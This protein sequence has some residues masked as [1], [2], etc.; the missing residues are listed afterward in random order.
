G[1]EA[2]RLGIS[3]EECAES[4][5]HIVSANMGTAIRMVSTDRG[6]DP[7]DQTLVAC[8]GAGGLHACEIAQS[9]SSH[10]ILITPYAG[11][12]S[13]FGATIMDDRHDLETTFYSPTEDLDF[14]ALNAAYEMLEDQAR[15]L[16]KSDGIPS[17]AVV[18]ERSAA[19]RYIGQSYEV[20]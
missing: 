6:R 4:I 7:R 5:A 14:D 20:N 17:D 1:I 12:A 3:I 10:K 13:A 11:V 9:N 19:M 18:V 8:G 16:M 15:E 2:E